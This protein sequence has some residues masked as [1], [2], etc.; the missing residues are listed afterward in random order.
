MDA[1]A[2]LPACGVLASASGGT[3]KRG[4]D[5][6]RCL[7]Y[8]T[9]VVRVDAGNGATVE[10]ERPCPNCSARAAEALS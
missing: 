9:V 6:Q 1:G 7:D 10:R 4:Y 5:C 2:D 8:K 3:P